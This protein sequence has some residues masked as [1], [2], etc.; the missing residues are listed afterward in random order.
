M[1]SFQTKFVILDVV[2]NLMICFKLGILVCFFILQKMSL[3]KI[4]VQ[5]Y[6]PYFI[7]VLLSSGFLIK[8]DDYS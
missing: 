6:L 5:F 3:R 4:M 7:D 2:H 8:A 1:Y